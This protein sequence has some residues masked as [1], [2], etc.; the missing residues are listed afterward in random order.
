MKNS[1]S[2]KITEMNMQNTQHVSSES[3]VSENKPL[4]KIILNEDVINLQACLQYIIDNQV[5]GIND[6]LKV[7]A[8]YK[9]Q[10]GYASIM[11]K[12][13]AFK[14]HGPA[15]LLRKEKSDKGEIKSF[16][17][18]VQRKLQAIY[19]SPLGGCAL[20][21][22]NDTHTWLRSISREFISIKTG[23]CFKIS[24]GCLYDIQNSKI[25]SAQSARYE[26]GIYKIAVDK[27][28][29]TDV[30]LQI[31]SL[32]SATRFLRSVKKNNSD[33]LYYNK[34]GLYDFR[35]KRQH[36]MKLNYSHLQPNE[37]WCGDGKMLDL[38]VI[39]DDW[40][41]VYRPWL[42]DWYDMATRRYCYEIAETENSESIANSLA[43]A[44]TN[45]GIPKSVKH[46]NGTS[47]L[48][49]RFDAMKTS[50]G[51]KTHHKKVKLARANPVESMHN[52]VDNMCKP[53]PGYTGNKYQEFPE[54]T[55]N[56]LKFTL[57]VHR[58]LKKIEKLFKDKK[59]TDTYYE[60][61]SNPESRM[62]ANKNRLLH[63]SELR[64]ILDEKMN[65][66]HN[67]TQRGLA[68][69]KLGEKVYNRLCT[70][71]L[72]N[73]MGENLNT[74]AGR[75][76]YKLK[77]GFVPVMAD[78]SA[79]SIYAMNFELRT[80]QLKRGITLN[81]NE[82]YHAAMRNYGGERV[83]IRYTNP[84]SDILYVFHSEELQKISDKKYMTT[85][86][87]KDLK[88][89]C[90]AEKQKLIDW[91]DKE[92][93][94]EQLTIQKNEERRLRETFREEKKTNIHTL[95]GIEGQIPEIHQAEENYQERQ[96]NKINPIKKLKFK[97]P[98]DE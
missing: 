70:D 37:L 88:F 97:G 42:M 87:F 11:N 89:I 58:D 48:S 21:A 46:D 13:K 6:V 67:R 73:E 15:K 9:V 52:I 96:M 5:K 38:L 32:S 10:L 92:S 93:F 66:Y 16:S 84:N 63:I 3:S 68:G 60:N 4:D 41:K 62:K 30:E 27:L 17:S 91:G 94:T 72:I 83:L 80:I 51:I 77:M 64:K 19:T 31:G 7:A 74:P 98:F 54:D 57:G 49:G 95:T 36:A 55:R 82:F 39:S 20:T 86:L 59:A 2:Y 26:P 28:N 81:N 35:N 44:I 25:I 23:E 12:L 79:V 53:L 1:T 71:E 78:P 29:D 14:S 76:E 56:K 47:Y 40:K 43:V 90:I 22:Y 34:F 50:F 61:I 75:Y 85:E 33:A 24:N 8:N 65:E 69:D 18:E 45:W